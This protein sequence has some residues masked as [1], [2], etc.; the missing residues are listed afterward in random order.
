[1]SEG[2]TF[3]GVPPEHASN[4]PG[5]ESSS[6]LYAGYVPPVAKA[7]RAGGPPKTPAAVPNAK[8]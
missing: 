1:M 8:K 2:E 3:F 6:D 5:R 4:L 7:P